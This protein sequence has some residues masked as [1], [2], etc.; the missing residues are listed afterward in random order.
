MKNNNITLKLNEIHAKIAK[1]ENEMRE[2][3]WMKT[4][5]GAKGK[6]FENDDIQDPTKQQ[7][8]TLLDNE[9]GGFEGMDKF[10]AE[11][12][13][14]WYAY[15]HHGGQNSNLYSALSVSEYKPSPLISNIEDTDDEMSVAMYNTLVDEFGGEEIGGEDYE[16]DYDSEMDMFEGDK[17]ETDS[18]SDNEEALNEELIRFKKIINY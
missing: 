2:D 17:N 4:R 12:A 16:P 11:E 18:P 1:E 3:S 7:M 8:L 15:N 10:S 5:A 13:I 14:Y 6:V 9:F